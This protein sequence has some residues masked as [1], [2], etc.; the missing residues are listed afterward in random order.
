MERIINKIKGIRANAKLL[1]YTESIVK[2]EEV[3]MISYITIF[4]MINRTNVTMD[5]LK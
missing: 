1:R 3:V 4:A 5:S 2:V